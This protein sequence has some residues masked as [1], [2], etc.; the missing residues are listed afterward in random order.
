MG[1][2]KELVE[3]I[4]KLQNSIEEKDTAEDLKVK[5]LEELT[6]NI[7]HSSFLS[8]RGKECRDMVLMLYQFGYGAVELREAVTHFFHHLDWLP[9]CID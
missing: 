6:D 7:Y 9:D 8:E 3:G 1:K 5:V 4:E 2:Y